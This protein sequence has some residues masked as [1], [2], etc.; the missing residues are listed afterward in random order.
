MFR[1]EQ[2][3]VKLVSGPT[4]I[5]TRSPGRSEDVKDE[6]ICTRHASVEASTVT[7]FGFEKMPLDLVWSKNP[8]FNPGQAGGPQR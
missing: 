3:S 6:G 1:K 7:R 5:S 2:T 4:Y 8:L